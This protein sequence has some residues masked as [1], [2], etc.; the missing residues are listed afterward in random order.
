MKVLQQTWVIICCVMVAWA[1]VKVIGFQPEL[2]ATITFAV[3][4]RIFYYR[5]EESALA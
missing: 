4:F 5:E 3:F 2:A 1:I